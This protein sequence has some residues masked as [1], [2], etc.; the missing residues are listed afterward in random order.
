MAIEWDIPI[1]EIRPHRVG[2]NDG[3]GCDGMTR[4]FLSR[5]FP[6]SLIA[7]RIASSVDFS[8]WP[9]AR[10]AASWWWSRTPRRYHVQA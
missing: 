10:A 5:E 7:V 4:Q 3:R 9:H 1:P 6:T 8:G 2:K